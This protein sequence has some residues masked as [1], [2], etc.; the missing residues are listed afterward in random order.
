MQ[1]C[2]LADALV[3]PSKPMHAS[4]RDPRRSAFTADV[5]IVRNA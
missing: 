4:L 5:R 2:R 1:R 3:A